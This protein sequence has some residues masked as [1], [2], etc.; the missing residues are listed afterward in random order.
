MA[1]SPLMTLLTKPLPWQLEPWQALQARLRAGRLPHALLLDGPAG[2]GKELFARLFAQAMLC[3]GTGPDGT[4]CGHCRSCTLYLAG[5]H[6]DVTI[7][8]PAEDASVIG[9]DRIR[10]L[11]R[12]LSMKSQQGGYKIALLRPAEQMNTAAANSLLKTLE[13]PAGQSLLLLVTDRPGRLLPTVRSRCQRVRFTPASTAQ[14][15]LWLAQQLPGT[16]AKALL[17][18]ADGAPLRALVC[19]R[20]GIS[21]QRQAVQAD[22]RNLLENRSHPADIAER[23]LKLGEA[24]VLSW[25]GGWIK[26]LIRLQSSGDRRWLRSPDLDEALCRSMVGLSAPTLYELLDAIEE[27]LRLAQTQVSSQLLLEDLLIRWQAA[28]RALRRA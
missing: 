27:G 9:I 25:L 16:D 12:F 11:T 4:P 2:L 21:E 18:L 24:D 6:P 1:E 14:G 15:E 26:D 28:G 10:E 22:L 17:S 13:E 3:L 8:T 23:W 5:N 19:A 7:A 20:G